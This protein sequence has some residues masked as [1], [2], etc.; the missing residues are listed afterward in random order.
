[1]A[2]V[3]PG[4]D[5]PDRRGGWWHDYVCPAHGTQ[6][7][8]PLTGGGFPCPHGCTLTGE[9]Y[10][11]A[12]A[13]LAH[14]A[15]ARE[16][17][18]L[19]VD[20]RDGAD[21]AARAAAADSAVAGLSRCAEL[22]R[23]LATELRTDAR[24]W[25]LAGRLFQQALTEAIWG[26]SIALAV[27]TLA[28]TVP[29]ER[30]R[31]AAELLTALRDGAHEARDTLVDRND[32]RNNYT[33]WLN[34]CGATTSRAL[35][36][37]GEPD[38]SDG[39]LTGPFGVI[40]HL[41]ASVLADG[42]EWEGST[43]Y[44]VFVARAYL[45]ALRGRADLLTDAVRSRLRDMVGVVASL[46]TDRDAVLP[47]L[48]DTPYGDAG[49][50]E[51][52]Y[53]LC[54]LARSLPEA[55]DLDFV[56]TPLAA[57]LPAVAA[58]RE[59]ESRDWYSFALSTPEGGAGTAEPGPA[60]RG[61]RLFAD[62]G[63]A[64]L[65][66]DGFRAVLDLGPH[67]GSH[68]HLD[69]LALYLYGPSAR[70][71]PAY[72][73][74]PYGHPWRRDHYRCT[75]AHPTLTVDDADQAEAD[76]RLLYWRSG[77]RWAEIGAT[78]D[79]YP[80]VRFERHVRVE[81]GWLL[82][83]VRAA[84]DDHERRYTLHLRADVEVTVRHTFSGAR[85]DWPGDGGLVGLHTALT[86]GSGPAVLTIAADLGPADDPQRTRPH[87][88]WEAR[89]EQVDFVSVYAPTATAEITGLRVERSGGEL[90]VHVEPA[91]AAPV[92]WT[93]EPTPQEDR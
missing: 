62:A 50:D 35:A 46:A 88:R 82:D 93:I 52:L 30:L 44:H 70:W 21:L 4:L 40:E 80:G 48:N 9:P 42:W 29:T 63:Y 87:L 20:V 15:V 11:G 83:V 14:Q 85:T 57:R 74:P 45:L 18:R 84:S 79:A 73:V 91:G 67:G 13:V 69:K 89:A 55:P 3:G 32:F 58:W 24:P 75:E 41:D 1:V 16:L 77:S 78:A 27:Q 60:A 65:A 90:T 12:W 59:S 86:T 33:A 25:M 68:G 43:Y 34:A 7:L 5:I 37:L 8:P 36:L 64:V 6:L 28:G 72:G 56:A 53:E 19:A 66:G 81:A 2:A 31:P 71:Q 92:S 39:W 17:R 49:W 38:E 26:T 51:E 47:A 23:R 61:N 76:G 54:L 10:A 22:Y